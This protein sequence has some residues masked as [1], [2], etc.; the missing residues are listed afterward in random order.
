MDGR[1]WRTIPP[2]GEIPE[3]KI[4]TG[5]CRLAPPRALSETV[6]TFPAVHLLWKCG[7]HKFGWRGFWRAVKRIFRED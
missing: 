4:R 6:G 1:D 3:V 7:Q 5:H 2:L